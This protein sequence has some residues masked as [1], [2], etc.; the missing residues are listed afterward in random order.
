MFLVYPVPEFNVGDKVLVRNHTRDVWD[1][2]YDVAYCGVGVMG[3]QLKLMDES[4]NTCKVN[5]QDVK[6]MY[7]VNELIKKLPDDETFGHAGKYHAHP[8]HI[9]YLHWSLNKNVIPDM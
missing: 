1:P 7:P 4:G 5:V 2:K 6:I 8:K 9:G 3:R